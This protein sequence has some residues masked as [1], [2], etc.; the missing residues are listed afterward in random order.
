LAAKGREVHVSHGLVVLFAVYSGLYA[1]RNIP[2][3][4]LLLILVIGPWLS[5]AMERLTERFRWGSLSAFFQ[6]MQGTEFSLHGHLW[7][8]AAIALTCW[9]A[10]HDGKLGATPL[11]DAHFSEK[12]FP[13]AAV[14]SLAKQN[15]D[16]AILSPDYWGGYLI[17]RLCPRMRVVVDDRH[18]YY[19]EGFLKSYLKM[20]NAEP[21]WKDFLRQHPAQYVLLPK[22]SALANLL[23]ETPGW[24]PFYRDEVAIAFA[25]GGTAVK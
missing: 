19:G 16:G 24:T 17:Y 4:S 21:G 12:R 22:D 13:V 3:S 23:L 5:N 1:S 9:T 20:V 11:M 15:P 25:P 10:A 2:V 18:D 6:R 8:I 7:P 14:N